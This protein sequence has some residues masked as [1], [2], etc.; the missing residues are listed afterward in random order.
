MNRTHTHIFNTHTYAHT[1]SLQRHRGKYSPL[2]TV[3]SL[4]F[5]KLT[6]PLPQTQTC[7]HSWSLSLSLFLSHTHTHHTHTH[8]HTHMHTPYTHTHTHKQM[9]HVMVNVFACKNASDTPLSLNQPCWFIWNRTEHS[10]RRSTT[11]LGWLLHHDHWV[12][13]HCLHV[14]TCLV[15]F[16]TGQTGKKYH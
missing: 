1:N 4:S 9:Q 3:F 6:L 16:Y 13:H 15:K 11:L 12:D 14:W 2:Q 8:T 7:T 5:L 10:S